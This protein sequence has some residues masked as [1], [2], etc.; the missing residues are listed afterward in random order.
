VR[1]RIGRLR[2]HR[3]VTIVGPGGIGKT[4]V[5]AAAA[6]QMAETFA[7]GVCFVALGAIANPH[8]VPS[9]L[10]SILGVPIAANEP[11][12]ETAAYLQHREML[13]VLDCCERVVEVAAILAEIFFQVCPCSP[14]P[15]NEPGAAA[16]RGRDRASAPAIGDAPRR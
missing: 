3:L 12:S 7:D 2:R 6:D 9:T 4:T 10:A 5:A 13:L 16:G 1:S 14:H 8:V 15:G 11:A